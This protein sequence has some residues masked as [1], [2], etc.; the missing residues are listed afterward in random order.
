MAASSQSSSVRSRGKTPTSQT[1]AACVP[2]GQLFSVS[3]GLMTT[4]CLSAPAFRSTPRPDALT[5]RLNTRPALGVIHEH[6]EAGARRRQEHGVARRRPPR[7]PSARPPPCRPRRARA[8]PAPAPGESA[9]RPRRSRRPTPS[10]P[11][12]RRADRAKSP[13]L[14]FPPRIT[15]SPVPKLWMAR[16]A[17]SML[18]AFE[19]LTNRTPPISVTG[20]SACSRP[21]KPFD[22]ARHRLRL[23]AGQRRDRRRRRDVR[24]QM[25]AEQLDR[26]QRHQDLLAAAGAP[27]DRVAG[28]DDAFRQLAL[29][30][31]QQPLRPRVLREHLRRLVVGVQHRPVVRRSGWRR[32][33][34]WPPRTPRRR[35]GDRGGRA[36]S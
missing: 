22:R 36:R 5:S 24:Q 13:P 19:S 1:G 32:C 29:D 7:T 16:S 12:A 10:A 3:T 33:A 25:P 14:N 27:H 17:D 20:S 30:R 6:V 4:H 35:R 21:V 31:E 23:D 9:G 26:R 2:S 15:T 11:S 18:V 28:D 8:P 34:P